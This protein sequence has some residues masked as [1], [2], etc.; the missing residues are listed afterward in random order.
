MLRRACIE[1]RDYTFDEASAAVR[2]LRSG[3]SKITKYRCPF[4]SDHVEPVKNWHI[5]HTPKMHTMLT[6]AAM[7]RARQGYP[8][9]R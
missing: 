7:I 2:R 5:G 6:L 8:L 4:A 1:K 3:D 9:D